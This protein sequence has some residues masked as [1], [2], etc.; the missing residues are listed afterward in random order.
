MMSTRDL[1][2]FPK[3]ETDEARE[4][5]LD[6]KMVIRD[7]VN[8]LDLSEYDFSQFD[9]LSEHSEFSAKDKTISL[10]LPQTLLERVSESSTKKKMPRQRYIRLALE[11]KLARDEGNAG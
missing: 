2:P 1:K 9:R 4:A 5:F 6:S 7:G 8:A 11:E 3:F 10:R